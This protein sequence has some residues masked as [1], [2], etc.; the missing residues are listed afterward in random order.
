[1][2]IKVVVITLILFLTAVHA[3]NL[4]A[5][6]DAINKMEKKLGSLIT[7]ERQAR[8]AS[9]RKLQSS[10]AKKGGGAGSSKPD[11]AVSA[12][13]ENLKEAVTNVQSNQLKVAQELTT[14]TKKLEDLQGKGEDARVKEM[15][16]ELKNLIDELKKTMK[17][18]EKKE[19]SIEA[20]EEKEAMKIGGIVTVDLGADPTEMKDVAMEVGKVELSANVNIA[21]SLVASIT[22]VAEGNL[23]AI[24]IDGA[25]AEFAPE[26]KPFSILFGQ[27][28]YNHGLLSTHLISDPA[29]LDIVETAAP[30]LT[31]NFAAGS[32]SP[33]IAVLFLHEDEESSTEYVLVDS[34]IEAV[35]VVES[36]EVNL[37]AGVINLD[38][39][40]LEES[41][42]RL[43]CKVHGDVFDLSVGTGIVVGP[44]AIDAEIFTELTDGDDAKASG[45]YAGFAYGITDDIE[46]A[47]RYDGLSEDSFGDI[48]HRI[49]VGATFGFKYGIFCAFEYGYAGLGTDEGEQEIALQL[50]LESA[51]KLPGF[52]R[53]TLTRK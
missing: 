5:L 42:A 26:N 29:L 16:L 27:H 36:E 52:H 49:G 1:M 46:A 43:S 39:S 17:I 23:S 30:G 25:V 34:T 40:F 4:S 22:L 11:S 37:F 41:V 9:D 19:E 32:F 47:F 14:V 2:K 53:K 20:E 7:Q 3:Q 51:L 13:I 21:T 44:A 18:E 35:T 24:R 48:E 50:G 28:G 15:A 10:I 33:G 6:M 31:V 12:A 38:L 45:Y 8:I